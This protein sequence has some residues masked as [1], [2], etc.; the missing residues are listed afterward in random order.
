MGL[1]SL[2]ALLFSLAG[3]VVLDRKYSLTFWRDP[4]KATWVMALGIAFFLVWDVVGIGL[5][6]FFR[7][8]T[9][10][11]T[12]VLLAPELPLEEPFF[13]ALMCYVTL[14]VLG[15]ISRREQAAS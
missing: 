9:T 12:G 6:I 7:G 4:T 3:Q 15:W 2:G 11:M 14:N 10:V 1:L 8:T 13:L 5:G